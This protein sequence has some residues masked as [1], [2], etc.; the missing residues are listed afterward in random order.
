MRGTGE[1]GEGGA[2][3]VAQWVE[4]LLDKLEDWNSHP[5]VCLS[6]GWIDQCT[7][8]LSTREAETEELHSEAVSQSS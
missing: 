6:A 4:F 5:R 2:G 8:N 1:R 3:A 7:H